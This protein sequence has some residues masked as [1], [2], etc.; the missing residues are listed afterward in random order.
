MAGRAGGTLSAIQGGRLVVDD[1]R[2][3]SNMVRLQ[4]GGAWTSGSA[5]TL[6]YSGASSIT[7]AAGVSVEGG[8]AS[9]IALSGAGSLTL[10]GD[11]SGTG[12][13][14]VTTAGGSGTVN[15]AFSFGSFDGKTV[16]DNAAASINTQNSIEI[17]IAENAVTPTMTASSLFPRRTNRRLSR[18]LE[19]EPPVNPQC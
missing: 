11:I 15:L 9:A 16:I 12:D 2:W 14:V 18:S 5:A 8:T 7:S 4:L 19:K 6:T 10:T 13:L 1:D 17:A 3:L